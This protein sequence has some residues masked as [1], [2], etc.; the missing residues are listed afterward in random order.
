M[1]IRGLYSNIYHV[2]TLFFLL[3]V[4]NFMMTSVEI[5]I[6]TLVLIV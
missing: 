3:V 4:T 2:R 1:F 5:A 6:I